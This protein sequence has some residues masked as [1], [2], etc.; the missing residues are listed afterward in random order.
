[1]NKILRPNR[2]YYVTCKKYDWWVVLKTYV[3]PTD[4]K[5]LRVDSIGLY[6]ESCKLN[7]PMRIDNYVD[8]VAASIAECDVSDVT[9]DKLFRLTSVC[10]NI[11]G[12]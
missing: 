8:S 6:R 4:D 3:H 11:S 5:W 12:K 9:E 1:M 7:Y 2:L 10:R